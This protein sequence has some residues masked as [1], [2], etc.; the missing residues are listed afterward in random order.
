[1]TRTTRSSVVLA[2]VCI[3]LLQPAT[4]SAAITLIGE[5]NIPG[6]ATDQSRLSGLLE[7]GVTPHNQAGGFGSAL[8][9][10]GFRDFYVATP[11]RGPADGT[12]S[13][14]D[15][16]YTLRIKLTR[17]GPNDYTVTPSIEATRLLRGPQGLYTGSAAA[18]DPTNSAKSLRFDPEGV[19]VSNCGRSVFI[20]DEYGPFLYEFDLESGK[21]LRA[22]KLPT[23]YLIDFPSPTAN[24]ELAQ[25]LSGRQANRGMEG[26]AISPDG[27]RLVGV[28][29][30][31]LIQDGA[32]SA[33][34][35]RV[36]TNNRIVEIDLDSGGIRE[37]LYALEDRRNGV[38]EILAVNDN[39][40]L[41]IERDGN[42][43][44]DARFKKIFKINL[45]GATDIRGLKQLP[46]TGIPAGVVAATKQPFLDL[47]DPAFGLAG[48]T[49]PEKMEGM[50]FGP[51]LKDGRHVLIVTND[52]DFFANQP[53]RFFVFAV[54]HLDLP[55]FQPQ[56]FSRRFSRECLAHGDDDKRH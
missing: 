20:S 51:D 47:L 1:M 42:A 11:D 52:N 38:N 28:M 27:R 40:F 44:T 22:I 32:L 45:A 53:N 54:D 29:Q 41:V 35:S 48:A 2:I 21:R 36:G 49:F 43:G 23:K 3:A 46:Q 33:T 4:V 34:L 13:Y 24:T 15:R 30:S 14:I 50:A 7:D 16:L 10:T 6:N 19:R 37:F 5:G 31:P 12:T 18:F 25:N 26:L 55:G 56:E 8:A 39:E 17:Q 9:Y